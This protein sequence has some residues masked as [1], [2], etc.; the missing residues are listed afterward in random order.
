MIW[1]QPEAPGSHNE[2]SRGGKGGFSFDKPNMTGL[3]IGEFCK[4]MAMFRT[5]L[6]S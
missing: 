4:K 1:V 3:L 2:Y 6:L 5:I